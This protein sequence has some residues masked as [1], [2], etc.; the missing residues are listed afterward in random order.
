[1]FSYKGD[2][3]CAQRSIYTVFIGHLSIKRNMKSIIS[4]K[5]AYGFSHLLTSFLVGSLPILYVNIPSAE[6]SMYGIFTYTFTYGYISYGYIS[7]FFVLLQLAGL[8]QLTWSFQDISS[9]SDL[10]KGSLSSSYRVYRSHDLTDNIKGGFH[11]C[12][13]YTTEVWQR[14]YNLNVCFVFDTVSKTLFLSP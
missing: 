13:F 6:G 11:V 5:S 8:N 3:V 10:P 9:N 2:V 14:L 12:R 7:I 1:M 4:L